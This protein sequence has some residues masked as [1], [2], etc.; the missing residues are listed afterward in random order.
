MNKSDASVIAAFTIM[1]ASNVVEMAG[2]VLPNR[3]VSSSEFQADSIVDSGLGS[4]SYPSLP[5]VA[6]IH[7]VR[8]LA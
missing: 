3:F 5:S 2:S 7:P 8:I 1:P 4:T 6:T